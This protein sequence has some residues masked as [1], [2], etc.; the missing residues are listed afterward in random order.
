MTQIETDDL[1]EVIW[2][3]RKLDGIEFSGDLI[4][5]HKW[6]SPDDLETIARLWR[7]AMRRSYIRKT[8]K[9]AEE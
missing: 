7:E 6:A 8:G 1:K 4:V 3:E 9:E 2:K 5:I